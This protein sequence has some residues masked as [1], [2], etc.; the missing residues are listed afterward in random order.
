MSIVQAY[1]S[2][3]IKGPVS[4]MLSSLALH[5]AY[6]RGWSSWAV[7][8]DQC[9]QM[10]SI[11]GGSSDLEG[12]SFLTMLD[13]L[14]TPNIPRTLFNPVNTLPFVAHA[15]IAT[16]D[17]CLPLLLLVPAILMPQ[18]V[19]TT[20][21]LQNC[22]NSITLWSQPYHLIC[23]GCPVIGV[24]L[25]VACSLFWCAMYLLWSGWILQ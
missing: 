11:S 12:S 5:V 10:W 18:F 21:T 14:W 13:D 3:P 20:N 8:E 16:L 24:G 22:D 15:L 7:S 9:L 2:T 4:Q 23:T 6:T 25:R 17:W 19:L 1:V